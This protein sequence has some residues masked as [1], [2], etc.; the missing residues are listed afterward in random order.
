MRLADAPLRMLFAFSALS[1]SAVAGAA[2]LPSGF[3][4][5]VVASGISNPTAMAF[6]PDGRLFV[7]QQTGQL[8]VV[9]NDALLP[10]PFVTISV[11]S[12]GERGLLGIAF[13]PD[14]GT[15]AFVYVYY[16]A[17][18]PVL[19]NRVSRFTADGDTA[20]PGSE[21]PILD[22]DPLSAT[23]HNGGAIRFG[24]DGLLYVAVGDN[25]N[26]VNAQ[27]LANRHGKI[28]RIGGDGSIPNDNPFVANASG[29]N[30]SIWAL[31]LR[32]PFTFAFQ[33]GS[34]RLFINDVGQG[35]W[36]EI[37]DGVAGANYGWPATEGPTTNP[38][39]AAP[40]HAYPHGDGSCAI[41]GGAFYD[42]SVG[43]YPASYAGSYFYGDFCGGWIRR[44]DPESGAATAFASGAS[45]PV[46]LQPGPDGNLYYLARGSGRV[47]RVTYCANASPTLAFVAP[48]TSRTNGFV[49]AQGTGFSP[50]ARLEF[51][52]LPS[53]TFPLQMGLVAPVSEVPL[54]ETSVRVVNLDGCRSNAVT[55]AVVPS[56]PCG[57]VGPEPAV[58]FAGAFV[59]RR[60]RVRAR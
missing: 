26:G 37:D 40:L 6:A 50:G 12:S 54:G 2:T 23:N 58:L 18:T 39:Y 5:S 10:A 8:R 57:E 24:P 38:L 25:A 31:G 44:V 60:R 22:L 36:E 4:E 7:A 35:S 34:G 56:A 55:L 46:D 52:S 27:T 43:T 49:L 59:A 9:K 28:L 3:S 20:L 17:T 14:F 51:G 13:D 16:T 1:L 53:A 41:T 29:A 15:N 48:S 11:N 45:Q 19:H 33:S 21:V 32:N 47:L 42:A 30:R